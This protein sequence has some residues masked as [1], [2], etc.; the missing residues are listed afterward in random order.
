MGSH[1]PKSRARDGNSCVMH[2][3]TACTAQASPSHVTRD[4]PLGSRTSLQKQPVGSAPLSDPTAPAAPL[5]TCGASAPARGCWVACSVAAPA[6]SCLPFPVPWPCARGQSHGIGC[7]PRP[8]KPGPELP[9]APSEGRGSR[10]RPAACIA[11]SCAARAL[12]FRWPRTPRRGAR[13][14]APA[15]PIAGFGLAASGASGT[16]ADAKSSATSGVPAGASHSPPLP[17][18]LPS[19]LPSAWSSL[20]KRSPAPSGSQ[21]KANGFCAG[22]LCRRARRARASARGTDER[23][24]AST[25]R[26]CSAEN[27]AA[28]QPAPSAGR[29][30]SSDQAELRPPEP[31]PAPAPAPVPAPAPAPVP[32]P[33]PSPAAPAVVAACSV[34]ASAATG[35]T[36]SRHAHRQPNPAVS[37]PAAGLAPLASSPPSLSRKSASP[38]ARP[39]ADPAAA[40]D[41]R[42][43]RCP[44]VALD[45]ARSPHSSPAPA[46]APA[47]AAPHRS[48]GRAGRATPSLT[49]LGTTVTAPTTSDPDAF[50]G[51]DHGCSGARP[52]VSRLWSVPLD[53]AVAVPPYPAEPPSAKLAPPAALSAPA[54]APA[55]DG[56]LLWAADADTGLTLPDATDT[57]E[58]SPPLRLRAAAAASRLPDDVA[59]RGAGT[60]ARGD[61]VVPR[62]DASAMDASAAAAL[63][64][65]SVRNRPT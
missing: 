23:A 59:G 5:W 63:A 33:S 37:P 1:A 58:L 35:A 43:R 44:A 49:L 55:P 16:R 61:N 17:P 48:T 22:P 64:A 54:P 51:T 42:T 38:A 34:E 24:L 56:G 62:G 30:T 31:A 50:L 14:A 60:V 21:S 57:A 39:R 28:H 11:S 27:A 26:S 3:A 2:A 46:P 13:K 15:A 36:S 41:R 20:A 52:A 45:L 10:L 47:P 4:A 29:A 19:A 18:P 25:A 6:R 32:S 65:A 12:A 9:I 53:P 8:A 40:A 7:Q